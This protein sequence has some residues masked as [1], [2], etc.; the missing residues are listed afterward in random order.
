[1]GAPAS[2]GAPSRCERVSRMPRRIAVDPR[3]G[4]RL[5]EL[6]DQRQLSLRD[7]AELA[8]HGKSYI[9]ELETGR[10]KPTPEAAANLD[11]ALGANGELALIVTEATDGL[12]TPDDEDRLLYVVRNPRRIDGAT[13]ESLHAVLAYQRRLEDA[14]GS[15]ALVAPVRGQA[16]M[17][18]RLVEQA[19]D[20]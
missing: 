14:I 19:P 12:W 1:M 9:S 3:F 18:R 2:A 6:R 4:A 17:L 10:K 11:R 7:L 16:D 5:R 15:A 13:I 20:N 8:H